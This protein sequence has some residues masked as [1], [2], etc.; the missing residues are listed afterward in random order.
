MYLPLIKEGLPQTPTNVGSDGLRFAKEGFKG[1]LGGLSTVDLRIGA[2]FAADRA[3]LVHAALRDA[4]QTIDRMPS[5]YMTYPT[6]DRIL[7]VERG[8]M[9]LAP[10]TLSLDGDYLRAFGWMRV[11]THLWRAMRRNAAWIEPTLKE[12]WARLMR[13]YA[14]G[15][16]RH[17]ADETIIRSMEWAD[18]DRDVSQARQI[19]GKL[20]EEAELRCVWTARLLPPDQFIRKA[21]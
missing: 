12:E 17:L 19:A 21:E 2:T 13:D 3:K 8:R 20:L 18:P 9:G 1:L 4:A 6:G 11:P 7:P 15:Q 16:N 5:T 10:A 14:K